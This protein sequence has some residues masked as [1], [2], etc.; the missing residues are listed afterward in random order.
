MPPGKAIAQAGHAFVE[1]YIASE[2]RDSHGSHAYR[3][4]PPGTKIACQG[5]LMR[6]L[7]A[8]DE[9]TRLN[10]PCALVHDVHPE[11][12]GHPEPVV[13]AL[14]IGLHPGA[15]R[16]AGRFGLWSPGILTTGHAWEKVS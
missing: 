16:I 13:T 7:K 10:I 1:A 15:S 8:H 6:I 3:D 5:T 11:F 12:F 4:P 14:G 2:S 9:C